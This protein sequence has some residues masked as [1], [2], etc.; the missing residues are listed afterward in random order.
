M[1]ESLL[2]IMSATL[3][4][5]TAQ[6]ASFDCKKASTFIE[7]AI[8]SNKDAS[9]LDEM[10]SESYKKALETVSKPEKL[11]EKQMLWLKNVR[12]KCQNIKCIKNTME[13]RIDELDL[14]T[15][16]SIKSI[17]GKY[18]SKDGDLEITYSEGILYFKLLVVTENAHIGEA[19]GEIVLRN[20]T[21]VYINE[22]PEFE[23]DECK[24]EFTFA[25][26][27]VRITQEGICGMG[28]NVTATGLYKSMTEA[29]AR[30]VIGKV[31]DSLGSLFY[32]ESEATYKKYCHAGVEENYGNIICMARNKSGEDRS[33]I[34]H[35][36]SG[37]DR[38][39][40]DYE[41]LPPLSVA[42]KF[43]IIST[44]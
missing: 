10:L 30:M 42:K 33:D 24:L 2:F 3:L 25:P 37:K 27:E 14:I 44:K 15:H 29:N 43:K 38:K 11:R 9:F 12:N 40:M 13:S 20:N 18:A 26:K 7:K 23:M 34:V 5:S 4:F 1:K 35:I 39:V 36:F 32:A 31:G 8:C 16:E 6:S 41:A 22:K 21:A 17:T 28:L 19:E